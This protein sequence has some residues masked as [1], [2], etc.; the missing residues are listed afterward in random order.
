MQLFDIP[1]RS[2]AL[3]VGPPRSEKEIFAE[4]F[5]AENIKSGAEELVILSNNF[6]EDFLSEVQTFFKNSDKKI[7]FIDCYTRYVGLSKP[8][9]AVTLRVSGPDALNEIAVASSSVLEKIKN[10]D[11]GIV[12]DTASPII[13]Q[14]NPRA[15]HR[16]LQRFIG[17]MKKYR[18]KI[19]ILIEEGMHDQKT[20]SML[21]SLTNETIYFKKRGNKRFIEIIKKSGKKRIS[22]TIKNGK[23]AFGRSSNAD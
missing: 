21:E 9:T 7:H 5:I 12:M 11:I 14:N 18:S 23:I 19:V 16:F 2:S 22:Y 17:R 1:F 13:M 6:P 8:D 20:M 10:R 15:V 4:Q 3:V